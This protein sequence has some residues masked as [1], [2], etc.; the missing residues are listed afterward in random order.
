[1]IYGSIH[2]ILEYCGIVFLLTLGVVVLFL[3]YQVIETKVKTYIFTKMYLL[4]KEKINSICET[5][6]VFAIRRERHRQRMR[7]KRH[8]NSIRKALHP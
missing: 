7:M 2:K 4:N 1:M 5:E 8:N 6:I 3:I